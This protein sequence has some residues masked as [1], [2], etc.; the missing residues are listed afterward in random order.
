MITDYF[1]LS[2]SNLRRRKVRSWLTMLGI[3]ISIATIFLLISLSL[4]LREAI[5]EQFRMLGTDKFFIQPKGQLGA[6]GTGGAVTLT[7]EDV[8]IINKVRGVKATSYLTAGNGK[9]EFN[10]KTRYY[11]IAAFP[12]ENV[13]LFFEAGG[14]KVDEG[15]PVEKTK[16]G[17]VALGSL[18]KTGNLFGKPIHTGDKIK[19]NGVEVSVATILQPVGNPSDD[20]NI[21]MFLDTYEKIFNKTDRADA[22]YVQI[23]PGENVED[24]ASRAKQKLAKFRNVDVDDPDFSISTPEELLSSFDL[25]LNI[26]TAFLAGIAAISLLVGGIGIMNTMYTSVLER[27]KEIGTMKAIGAK[28]SDIL[29]IFLIESGMLGLIGGLIGVALGF[30]LS[31]LIEIIATNYL[32]TTLLK[33]AAPAYLILGCLAFAFL[34]GLA[35]GY[36]PARQASSLKPVDALRYE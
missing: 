10:G 35:S 12:R 33:A 28:N 20:Q 14:L 8:D 1:S 25:I 19:I 16:V 22:I 4:G 32:S 26:I 27:T 6:P 29:Y 5:N 34:I 23:Q 36:L 17:D 18:Y 31:K 2:L 7:S 9:I 30:S 11:F 3:F 24:V 21:Y 15:K 13:N